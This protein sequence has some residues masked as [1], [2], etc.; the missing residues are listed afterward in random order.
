MKRPQFLSGIAVL[1]LGLV[2]AICATESPEV[3]VAISEALAPAVDN[4]FRRPFYT[5]GSLGLGAIEKSTNGGSASDLNRQLTNL[6]SSICSV[7]NQFTVPIAVG[8]GKVVAPG[9]VPVR[10]R[11]SGQEWDVQAQITPVMPKLVK[12]PCSNDAESARGSVA[13]A[14]SSLG[15]VRCEPSAKTQIE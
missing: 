8:L 9:R 4:L 12:A 15:A 6:A 1:I 13:T 11:I 2:L 3:N 14:P 5:I 7:S 10:P